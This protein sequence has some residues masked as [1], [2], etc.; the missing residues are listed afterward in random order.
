MAEQKWAM[1]WRQ[2]MTRA[3]ADGKVSG[4][5]KTVA[6]SFGAPVVGSHVRLCL[7]NRLGEKPV[8]IEAINL[9]VGEHALPVNCGGRRSFAIPAGS[10]CHTDACKV[11][12]VRGERLELR[13]YYLDDVLDC[14][15]IEDGAT[16]LR[17]SHVADVGRLPLRKPLLAR[18]LGAAN[19]LPAI[20]AVEVLTEE[21][22]QAIVAFGDSITAMSKWTKP[23]AQRLAE[24]YPGEYVLLNAGI[25]GNCLLYKVEGAM[26]QVFGEPGVERF[27]HDVLD[28]PN[29]HTVI[30]GLGVNDVSYLSEK[31][32]DQ[33]SLAAYQQA[34]S[35]IADQLHERGVRMAMQTITP[36]LGV[37]RTMGKYMPPME[38]LRLQLNDWIRGNATLF[39]YVFDA[40]AVVR[41]QREDGWYFRE[42]IHMGDH[43]HPNDAG[44]QLL[45]DA[46]D[47]RGLVG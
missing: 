33:I 42:G 18:L 40:E 13:M 8:R 21:P 27:A 17:G 41:D 3:F 12:V 14:N 45:A 31:T 9:M 43:L 34:V 30:F 47:L 46:W 38:E 23:L 36:R 15:M 10:T 11:S 24:A 28:V 7:S 25:S 1:V 37:A 29:L 4:H 5:N 6:F 20:E 39:D 35:D 44:G 19:P 26:G 32:S 16:L 22:A 2:A